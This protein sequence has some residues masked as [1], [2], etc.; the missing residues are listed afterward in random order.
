MLSLKYVPITTIVLKA[1][2][3]N[4]TYSSWTYTIGASDHIWSTG[5]KT[6][7]V[8]TPAGLPVSPPRAVS[9]VVS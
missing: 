4:A 3:P 2:V 9:L 1:L 5:T 7:E 6:I 8:V